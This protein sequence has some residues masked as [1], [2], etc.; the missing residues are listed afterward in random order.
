M[1]DELTAPATTSAFSIS[2]TGGPGYLS[3]RFAR[4]GDVVPNATM[5][6]GMIRNGR[7]YAG[8][9]PQFS[10]LNDDLV[11]HF[12]DRQRIAASTL[13]G[14]YLNAV[15]PGATLAIILVWRSSMIDTIQAVG[16]SIAYDENGEFD[17]QEVVHD[18]RAMEFLEDTG[19][20]PS[21]Q[22]EP[23]G[24]PTEAG[25]FTEV[26]VAGYRGFAEERVLRLAAPTGEPGSGLTVLVGS[27]N[28]GKSTFLE[29]LHF[30]AMARNSYQMSFA[31]PR[32]HR[33]RDS[34][35]LELAHVDGRRLK[36]ETA[37]PGGSQAF[38]RWLPE[39]AAP[40]TFDIHVTPSRRQFSPYFGNMGN[41]DRNWAMSGQ[42]YSRTQLREEFVGRLRKVDRDPTSRKEFDALL[43]RVVGYPVQWTID[44]IATGQQFLKMMEPDGSWYTS[45][46][47]GDGLVSLLFIVDALYDSDPGALIAIDEPELSL[48]P[49]LIRRLAQ[50]LSEY[51][52]KRQ[53]IISTHSPLLIDWADIANGATIARIYK[54]QG[55]SEIAQASPETLKRISALADTRNMANPHTVGSVAREALFLDDGVILTEGQDDVAYFPRVLAGLGLPPDANVYGWGSGGVSNIPKIARL[56]VEL[57]FT[58]VGAILDMDGQ[59]GT[60]KA[61]EELEAMSPVVLARQIP[62]PDIRFKPATSAREA[63]LGLL[64]EDKVTVRPEFL[65]EARTVIGEVLGHVAGEGGASAS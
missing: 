44:E 45:E 52:A 39:D 28:S 4:R 63:V 13:S 19:M 43:E 31:Q 55:R 6:V 27:N 40:G 1:P 3:V 5:H 7:A 9:G 25:H 56:F 11:A 60:Q 16:A 61:L 2:W 54:T 26:C 30:L 38:Y 51:S 50:V 57:G 59:P 12:F 49:Q 46:G 8:D 64:A 29:A 65:E 15:E 20:I 58:R 21:R 62:A 33:D 47:L 17:V 41:E 14:D 48:H 32:R 24:R 53:I 36:V 34:V 37:R 18:H 10:S 42:E 22:I 23:T 35:S